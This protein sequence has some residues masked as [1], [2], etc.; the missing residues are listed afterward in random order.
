MSVVLRVPSVDP[1]AEK[2]EGGF[3]KKKKEKKSQMHWEGR[4]HNMVE[5]LAAD[6]IC[7]AIF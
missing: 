5:F 6:E 3:V 2:E 1:T 7:K 4:N